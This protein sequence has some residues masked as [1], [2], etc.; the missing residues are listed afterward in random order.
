MERE[1]IKRED[2]ELQLA[3]EKIKLEDTKKIINVEIMK[4]L[5]KRKN[6]SNYILDYRKNVIEEFRDDEDKIIE[7]FDHERY[8][9]EEAFK[10]I[11]RRLKELTQLRV[12]PYFGKVKFKDDDYNMEEEIYI[13]KFGVTP[14]GYFEPVIVDWRAP[15]SSLFYAG[16]TGSATY[17]SP[18]GKINTEIIGRRQF[19]IKKGELQGMF[20]SDLDIKD[21]ILQIVLSSSSG[22]KLK[23]IIM[24]IQKEQDMII[25][26]PRS[27]IVVVNGVA[28]SG[29]TTIALHRI[30][31][32]MYNH[33]K[34]LENKVLILGPNN[35]FME[36]IS[37]VLPSLGEVSVKQQTF[38]TFAENILD[39]KA[40]TMNF[41][42]YIEAV[43]KEDGDLISN[44]NYKN[45]KQYRE[46]LDK[47]LEDLNKN[48]FSI[49]DVMFKEQ[50]I[51]DKKEIEEMF[52]THYAHMPL[53]RRSKRIKRVLITRIKDKRD[54][55]FRD[56]EKKYKLI[57][58]RLTEEEKNLQLNSLEFNRKIE[59][60]EL[61]RE[62]MKA[63]E[64]LIWLHNESVE[65][66]YD[67][68][69]H[70]KPFIVDDLAPMLYIKLKLEGIKL[71][72]DIKHVVIDEA[73]DYNSL[74]FEVIKHITNCKSFTIVGDS[75]QRLVNTKEKAAM[76]DLN[77]IFKEDSIEYFNLNKS[78]RSTE[79]IMDY[80]NKYLIEDK[81]V[82]FVRE[83]KEV[84][85]KSFSNKEELIGKIKDSLEDFKNK[86]YETIAII[87]RNE[88][89]IKLL[90][91]P[92]K[93]ETSIKVIGSEDTIYTGGAVLIP[94]Y[95]A[96]GLE[97]DAV[98]VVD[99]KS[100]REEDLVKYV[101]C[102]RALHELKE[103]QIS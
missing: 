91:E 30:A 40:T 62:V 44:I 97:F 66:I 47:T 51:V 26:R 96:K 73:Q 36:Y 8:V 92:L 23:D 28:G 1:D 43:I 22:D 72:D 53:F 38:K 93:R 49:K 34:L 58:E 11:D 32:L 74:Q 64:E 60:R 57:K 100:H 94:S 18:G 68:L 95:F 75:N 88:E 70:N 46:N 69:N 63:K 37:T 81:I 33:R 3:M 50:T 15:V 52:F 21:E 71:E 77:E 25:R 10:T 9:K 80:A 76:T 48:Y 27:E 61:I 83:G 45:S 31:Y 90:E 12:S 5:D 56:I 103:F 17:E 84:E 13:G 82:P 85:Q 4:Y 86:D 101:M 78:Y 59:I 79:Q 89:I 99:Y 29:K 35:I 102:T 6:I 55:Y 65:E 2:R 41:K 16:T 67:R 98:I 20:D 42:D 87:C 39:L 54:E 7:Y 24:T 19:I 14:D